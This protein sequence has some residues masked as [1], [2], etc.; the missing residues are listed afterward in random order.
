MISI[1]VV[2]PTCNR[3]AALLTLLDCLDHSSYKPEEIIIVDSGERSPGMEDY[4]HYGHL[5]LVKLS[6]CR[7]ACRQ[8]NTGILAASGSWIFIC[9][10]DIEVPPDYLERLLAHIRGHPEAGAVSGHVL[11]KVAGRWTGSYPIRSSGELLF[12]Y[13]FGLGTWG[14]MLGGNDR[15]WV[16]VVKNRYVGRG[17]HIAKSGW[18]VI[19][20]FSGEYFRTPVWGLGASLIRK[21]WLLGSMYDERLE[22]HGAGDH[23]GVASGF[24]AEGIHIV[25]EALVYHHASGLN[26][27]VRSRQYLLRIFALD[28]FRRTRSG[29]HIDKGWL[30]WSLTGSLLLF[31]KRK[32]LRMAGAALQ[33]L[34][35]VASGHNPYCRK[36]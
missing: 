9:D 18:P 2:I 35:S 15:G 34:F 36:K 22:A 32:D 33:G 7:S 30:L 29:L 23:Y 28:Y 24:P 1:S 3:P 25:N 27:L 20:D 16:R 8:R 21:D 17:N 12:S 10:D 19:A 5:P 26:R 11:Q 4:A 14:E 31:L 13:L 6:S